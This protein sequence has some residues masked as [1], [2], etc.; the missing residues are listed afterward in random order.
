MSFNFISPVYA[1]TI[2]GSAAW[3]SAE[4]AKDGVVTIGGIEC[5]IQNLLAPLPS[6]IALA[7]VGMMIFAGIKILNAGSDTKAYAAGWATFTY[8]LIGLVLLSVVWFVIVLIQ[9]FTGTNI[10]NFGIP[11]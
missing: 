4:C 8:A 10:T 11:N 5:I 1:D 2:T 9:N 6:L 3:E 7:A